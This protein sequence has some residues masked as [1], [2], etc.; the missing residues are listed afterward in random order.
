MR[1]VDYARGLSLALPTYS[2]DL[3]KIEPLWNIIKQHIELRSDPNLPFWKRVDIDFLTY[4]ALRSI[5]FKCVVS[6]EYSNRDCA[7]FGAQRGGRGELRSRAAF[8]ATRFPVVFAA[9]FAREFGARG[10]RCGAL[11]T[12]HQ[13]VVRRHQLPQLLALLRGFARF[14]FC[15]GCN[16]RGFLAAIFAVTRCEIGGNARTF[17]FNCRRFCGRNRH[18]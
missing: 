1:T 9:R 10:N 5:K 11:K 6:I 13:I 8:S 17:R 15:R 2:P 12:L 7:A 14:A 4:N 16:R 18:F 3:N